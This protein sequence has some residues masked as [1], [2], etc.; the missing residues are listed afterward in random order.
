MECFSFQRICK[1]ITHQ[2]RCVSP[3][4]VMIIRVVQRISNCANQAQWTSQCPRS[5]KKRVYEQIVLSII[6]HF[7]W[8]RSLNLACTPILSSC[9]V[10]CP[11]HGNRIFI[12]GIAAGSRCLQQWKLFWVL[13]RFRV[14]LFLRSH[15][16]LIFTKNLIRMAILALSSPLVFY[17]K[18]LDLNLPSLQKSPYYLAAILC[19]N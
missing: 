12:I 4:F 17:S 5:G 19:L 15:L 14:K 7:H 2:V 16:Y 8:N 3:I 18:Y 6:S 9:K 11:F 1:R 13:R 10:S